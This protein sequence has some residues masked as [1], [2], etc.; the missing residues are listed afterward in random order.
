MESQGSGPIV[1]AS[2]I[3]KTYNSGKGVTVHALR[4]ID[5]SVDQG[6]S[7]RDH[8]AERMREDDSAQLPFRSR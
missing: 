8:G 5:L 7:C 1:V 2:G 4:G 6:R 3:H